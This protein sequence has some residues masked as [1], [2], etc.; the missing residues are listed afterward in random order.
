MST[1]TETE[2]ANLLRQADPAE[3]CEWS[4]TNRTL[5]HVP[6][7][8]SS[9]EDLLVPSYWARVGNANLIS[10]DDIIRCIPADSSWFA[11]LLV[12][13][14]G[15]EGVIMMVLRAGQ[16]DSVAAPPGASR[17]KVDEEAA[18]YYAGPLLKWQVVSTKDGR[19]LKS[20][21][22]TQ[23]EA[24]VWLKAHREMQKNTTKGRA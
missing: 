6:S 17:H 12:R 15:P 5:R 16:F 21:C 3:L 7:A 10:R 1:D 23:D 24:A 18:F 8:A 4:H 22:A 20:N 19:V 14:V 11:E 2:S 13:D 9:P